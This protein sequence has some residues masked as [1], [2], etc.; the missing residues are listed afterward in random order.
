VG[1]AGATADCAPVFN[2]FIFWRS[3]SRAFSMAASSAGVGMTNTG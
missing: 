1:A 3:A 2:S